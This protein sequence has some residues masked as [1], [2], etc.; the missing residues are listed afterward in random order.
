MSLA[1]SERIVIS[2]AQDWLRVEY[3]GGSEVPAK[4]VVPLIFLA[5]K[6]RNVR[7]RIRPRD[8][9]RLA[10]TAETGDSEADL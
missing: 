8:G 3:S 1:S 2:I 10:Q 5:G 4:I 6:H 9:I 7:L